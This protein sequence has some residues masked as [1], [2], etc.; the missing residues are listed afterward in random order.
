MVIKMFNVWYFLWLAILV[1][2]FVGLY[3]LLRNKSERVK[4]TV[5]FSL[6]A[7]A[8]LLHFLK[9]FFPPYSTDQWRFFN[10]IWFINICAANI[11]IFPFIYLSK[12]QI[13]RDYMFY[14]GVLSGAVAILYPIEPI[15][16]T[17]PT[18][19]VLDIIRFY[20]H[21]GILFI[22]PLLMVVFGLHKLDYR[23]VVRMPACLLGLFLFIMFNQIMQ[24]EL[25][26][27]DVRGYAGTD[28]TLIGYKNTSYIWGTDDG[29][30]IGRIL[31]FFTPNV[32]KSIPV[33][34]YAG[35]DKEWPF[36]WLIV[37]VYVLFT[38]I[39]FGLS[40]IFE[41]KKFKDD[42]GRVKLKLSP[43]IA[44]LKAKFKR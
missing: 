20:I 25:G 37:P 39:C 1:G 34:K 31:R 3:F 32:F 12:N 7:F 33:G 21:H 41:H 29:D 19:E 26:F 36:V 23:R 2:A 9:A 16:K 27:A 6:L 40:M 11:L 18:G 44:D 30:V 15:L 43:R 4:N 13:L 24:Q 28:I 17:D 5:L 8:L 42:W 35:V 10:D 22:V 14:I 38:P